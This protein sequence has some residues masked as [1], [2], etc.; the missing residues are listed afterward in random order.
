MNAPRPPNAPSTPDSLNAPRHLVSTD[1]LAEHLNDPRVIV[2]DV[3]WYMKDKRGIDAYN[4]GHIPGAWFVDLDRDLSSPPGPTQPGRHPLPSAE[5]FASVLERIGVAKDSI[6]VAYDDAGGS[7]AARLWWMLRYFGPGNGRLL[8]G[9]LQAWVNAGHALSTA[10]PAPKPRTTPLTLEARPAMVVDKTRVRALMEAKSARLLD[11]RA[12][13]RFEGK[14]E[15]IDKRPGHIP[16]ATN[17]PFAANLVAP[18]GTF[19]S[20]DDL[21][22]HY[23]ALGA[24]GETPVIAYCGS[25]VTACHDLFAL[26]MTGREDALLY[27]GSWS[28]WA[29]D[30]SLPAALGPAPIDATSGK[31]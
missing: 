3:R 14:V 5:H 6:V 11:A 28:D 29:A 8:D 20:A 25:G 7:I 1:W 2:A 12:P 30:P 18:G 24:R 27:V 10:P 13:E 15:P 22:K 23:D 4:A 31:D 19:R 21:A 16:G 26:A 9:G 17:A